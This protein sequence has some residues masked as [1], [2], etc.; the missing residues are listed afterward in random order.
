MLEYFQGKLPD[1]PS[2]NLIGIHYLRSRSLRSRSR[3]LSV[4]VNSCGNL[5]GPW[6]AHRAG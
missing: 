1:W 4:M 3:S 2:R 6:G 5:T